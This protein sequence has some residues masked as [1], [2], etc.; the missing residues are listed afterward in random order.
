MDNSDESFVAD[1]CDGE[2]EEG[3]TGELQVGGTEDESADI[4]QEL[5]IDDGHIPA[6]D[7]HLEEPR[8]WIPGETIFCCERSAVHA[9]NAYQKSNHCCMGIKR[10]VT[11][12]PEKNIK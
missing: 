3:W 5:N 1:S 9:V 7:C 10:T 12:N 2:G 8:D 6:H 4:P 11:P